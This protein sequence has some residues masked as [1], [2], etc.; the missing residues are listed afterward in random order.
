MSSIR[1]LQHSWWQYHCCMQQLDAAF[2]HAAKIMMAED[3]ASG[4][5]VMQ[6]L[7]RQQ[8]ECCIEGDVMEWM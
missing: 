8:N 5:R 1:W 4:M 6:Q 3:A 2:Q 7:Q